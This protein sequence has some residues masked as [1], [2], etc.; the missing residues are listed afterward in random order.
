[1]RVHQGLRFGNRARH[2]FGGRCQ[3]QLRAKRAQQHFTLFAH[4]FRHGNRQFVA[5]CRTYHR[6]TD[7]RIAA[8]CLNNDGV[9]V[10]FARFLGSLDHCFG[11]AVFHAAARIEKFQLHGNFRLQSFGQA[12]QFDQGGVADQFG[13]AVCNFHLLLLNNKVST[14]RRNLH[15]HLVRL[16]GICAEP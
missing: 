2:T 10:D 7:T 4:T 5:A 11:N 3:N 16:Q 13:D 9:F 1:M 6:Q 8:G 15:R 12:V 14:V